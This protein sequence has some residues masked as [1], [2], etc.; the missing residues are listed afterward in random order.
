MGV[1]CSEEVMHQKP[2]TEGQFCGK[3]EPSRL[4]HQGKQI[5]WETNSQHD[6]VLDMI[7]QYI[8]RRLLNCSRHVLPLWLHTLTIVAVR[9]LIKYF[10]YTLKDSFLRRHCIFCPLGL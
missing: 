6:A 4:M 1:P 5:P 7:L 3:H 8:N 9:Q 10:M 2:N